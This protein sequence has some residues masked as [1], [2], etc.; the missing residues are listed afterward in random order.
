LRLR[1]VP[2]ATLQK[3]APLWLPFLPSIARRSKESVQELY[4]KVMAREVWLTLVWDDATNKPVALIG[5]RFHMRGPDMI[6]EWLWMTGHNHRAWIDLLPEFEQ[7][8][9]QAGAVEC[10]P[11]CRPGWVKILKAAGYKVT[12]I[13]LEKS[14]HE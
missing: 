3:T 11:L 6:A 4:R 10:R 7:L 13:Q 2:H 9:R 12:H 8:L 5:V 14:L 1:P